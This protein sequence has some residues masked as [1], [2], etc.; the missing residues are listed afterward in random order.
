MAAVVSAPLIATPMAAGLIYGAKWWWLLPVGLVAQVVVYYFVYGITSS[1]AGQS[2][3][4]S[5]GPT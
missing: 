1:N 4:S 2:D 3:A 5:V